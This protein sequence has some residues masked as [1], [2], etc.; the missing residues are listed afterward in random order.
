M[1]GAWTALVLA[2]GRRDD[3]LA[4][5]EGAPN[6]TLIDVHG[7]PIL[8]RVLDALDAAPS[9][10]RIVVAIEDADYLAGMSPRPEAA[11]AADSVVATVGAGLEQLGPPLLVVTGDHALLTSGMVEEFIAGALSAGASAAAAMAHQDVV[12]RAH[13]GVRR[14]YLKFSDGG[15]SGCNL[16]ALANGE[17][18]RAL[19]FWRE[20]D[21]NRKKPWALIRAVD[22]SALA[23]YAI[24][25]L[26]LDGAMERLSRKLDLPVAVVRM[27][28]GEAAI[29][30]DKP[31]DLALVRRIVAART[32]PPQG[33]MN[34]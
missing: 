21:R 13:P 16:F 2:A 30:V 33:R 8:Q 22:P 15:Y 1:S 11:K 19:D 6:K 17:A 28:D 4:A 9:V 20:I 3:P 31:D 7:R 23:L 27:S 26:S 18:A 25:R 5:A 10:G 32:L 12:E 24:G 14:T 34:E 29:D